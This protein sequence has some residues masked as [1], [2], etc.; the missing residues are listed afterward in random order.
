MSGSGQERVILAVETCGATP[1]APPCVTSECTDVCVLAEE[2]LTDAA[3][4]AEALAELIR[5]FGRAAADPS[6]LTAI[7][8]VEARVLIPECVS[9][10]LWRGA[11]RSLT[12]CRSRRW[13][14]WS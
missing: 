11:L 3:G 4:R 7:A 6:G 1:S 5:T 12:A 14:R 9:V 2:Y 8:F 13:G 10:S